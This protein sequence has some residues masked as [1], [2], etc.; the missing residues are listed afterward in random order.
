MI[1][2]RDTKYAEFEDR[3]KFMS[4]ESI[5][6]LK[7]AAE[8]EFVPMYGMTFVQFL[9]AC[10]DTT[11]IIG[12]KDNPT[13]LQVY[14]EK[15]FEEFKKEFEEKIKSTNVLPTKDEAMAAKDLPAQTFAEGILVFCLH[16]FGLHNFREAEQLTLG[17][18]II[19]RK[20]AYN[21]AMFQ[22][23]LNAIQMANINRPK[24]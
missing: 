4:D 6:I 14:W 2:T 24:K 5:S 3:E 19:A 1:V 7:K 13:V 12:K 11:T 15:R 22:R 16:Y 9:Q 20:D 8:V 17:D 18:I 10:E 23:R 21:S